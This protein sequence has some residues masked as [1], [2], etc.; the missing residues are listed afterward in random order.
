MSTSDPLRPITMQD[1]RLAVGEGKLPANDVLAGCNAELR[2]RAA[3]VRPASDPVDLTSSP[4]VEPRGEDWTHGRAWPEMLDNVANYWAEW[5][6]NRA[7]R[8]AYSP[9]ELAEDAGEFANGLADALAALRPSN[10]APDILAE[11]AKMSGEVERLREALEVAIDWLR[12]APLE[13]GTCCCGSPV[14][15]HGFGDGHSPVD[16]L[17]YSAGRLEERLRAALKATGSA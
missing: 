7:G 13:S 6:E 16:E 11:N 10:E 12:R 14:D 4:E 15:G 5:E 8:G 2:R 17:A 3:L 1:V 9:E